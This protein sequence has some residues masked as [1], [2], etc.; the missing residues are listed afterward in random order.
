[1]LFK[2]FEIRPGFSP[3]QT[4]NSITAGSIGHSYAIVIGTRGKPTNRDKDKFERLIREAW[5]SLFDPQGWTEI[6]N[7]ELWSPPYGLAVVHDPSPPAG[8]AGPPTFA[9]NGFYLLFAL[10][11]T[12]DNAGVSEEEEQATHDAIYSAIVAQYATHKFKT[13]IALVTLYNCSVQVLEGPGPEREE[14][15]KPRLPHGRSYVF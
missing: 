13:R 15:R 9:W 5:G 8:E 1:M 12:A 11:E 2:A 7:Q 3:S 4:H 6:F 10:L 14:E